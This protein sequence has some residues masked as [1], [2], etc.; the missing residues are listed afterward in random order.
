MLREQESIAGEKQ[1]VFVFYLSP[2]FAEPK[3]YESLLSLM[4][5]KNQSVLFMLEKIKERDNIIIPIYKFE[6]VKNEAVPMRPQF[7]DEKTI[8]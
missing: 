6:T 8:V 3:K 5:L 4:K 2:S 1:E 7:E